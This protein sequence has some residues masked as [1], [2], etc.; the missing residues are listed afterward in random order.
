MCHKKYSDEYSH[1][2]TTENRAKNKDE[3]ICYCQNLGE[4]SHNATAYET[5]KRKKKIPYPCFGSLGRALREKTARHLIPL[6][7]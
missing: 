4:I 1:I 3:Q 2:T 5:G 7:L 6:A